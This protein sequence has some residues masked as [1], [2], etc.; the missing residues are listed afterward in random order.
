[1][2]LSAT[3]LAELAPSLSDKYCGFVVSGGDGRFMG[4]IRWHA[5]DDTRESNAGKAK[6]KAKA[7]ERVEKRWR[8]RRRAQRIRWLWEDIDSGGNDLIDRQL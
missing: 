8:S 2:E 6:A 4:K 7:S 3:A 5:S 1:L